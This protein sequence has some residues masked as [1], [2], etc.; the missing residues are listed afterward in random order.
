MDFE[1]LSDLRH[2]VSFDASWWFDRLQYGSVLGTADS[3]VPS[4]GG[5]E[6]VS[7]L[8]VQGRGLD[9]E[10]STFYVTLTGTDNAGREVQV[11][12]E[13]R[14]AAQD[15]TIVL[16]VPAFSGHEGLV[17]AELFQC[18]SYPS[19]SK[20]ALGTGR[21]LAGG[22]PA[23]RFMYVAAWDAR[24]DEQ[25]WRR[26]SRGKLPSSGAGRNAGAPRTAV[27]R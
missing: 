16:P 1:G 18:R 9:L 25:A 26:A 21:S 19:C 20:V 3:L 23:D 17:R 14:A 15:G 24:V 7:T 2:R 12:T 5:L 6:P 10:D 27:R 4:D 13:V 22:L 8:T 11:L